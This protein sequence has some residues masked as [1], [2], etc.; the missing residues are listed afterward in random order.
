MKILL[1]NKFYSFHDGDSIYSINLTELIINN[2]H[3]VA[4]F[5]MQHP[6]NLDTPWNR[7]FPTEVKFEI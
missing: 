1:A 2:G 3:K 5:A 6:N 4:I 7:Y